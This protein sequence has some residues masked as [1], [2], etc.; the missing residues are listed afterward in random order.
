VN[1]DSC[2]ECD[3]Q[4]YRGPCAQP[5]C[6]ELVWPYFQVAWQF[7]IQPTTQV[8]KIEAF[9]GSQRIAVRDVGVP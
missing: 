5:G 8:F 3:D 4:G 9:R 2:P 1:D 6:I 7:D